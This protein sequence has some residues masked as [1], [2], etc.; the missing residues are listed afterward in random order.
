MSGDS[1]GVEKDYGW[2]IADIIEKDYGYGIPPFWTER[3]GIN[4]GWGG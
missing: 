2:G 1:I 4:E 3:S